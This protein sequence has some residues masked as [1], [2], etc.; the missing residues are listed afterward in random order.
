[1]LSQSSSVV[2]KFESTQGLESGSGVRSI[3]RPRLLGLI[4]TGP[5]QSPPASGAV[6][7]SS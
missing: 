7:P 6:S 1:M 4:T 5:K 2:R 3:T